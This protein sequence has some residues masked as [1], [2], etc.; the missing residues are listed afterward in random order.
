MPVSP[1]WGYILRP[2]CIALSGDGRRK[3][4]A[5]DSIIKA[6]NEVDSW[7]DKKFR[8]LKKMLV[9]ERKK[10]ESVSDLYFFCLGYT[11]C[12]MRRDETVFNKCS[13]LALRNGA[14]Y[15]C[16]VIVSEDYVGGLL[17]DVGATLAHRDANVGGLAI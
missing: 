11:G 17:G 16:E 9:G 7:N 5:T 15:R 14:H 10:S 1:Q 12:A 6:A 3:A 13:P 8:M 4:V 2:T